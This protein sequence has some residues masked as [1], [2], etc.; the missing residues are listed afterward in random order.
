MNKQNKKERKIHTQV[1]GRNSIKNVGKGK[2]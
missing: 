2:K 1:Q